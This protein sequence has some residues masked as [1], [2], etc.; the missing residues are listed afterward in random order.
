MK[1]KRFM[2]IVYAVMLLV[3]VMSASAVYLKDGLVSYY[4]F[5]ETSGTTATDSLGDNDGTISGVTIDQ[6]GIINKAYDFDGTNDFVDLFDT[7][8]VQNTGV[9]TISLWYKTS[10]TGADKTLLGQIGGSSGKGFFILR[11]TV[12]NKIDFY[13]YRGSSGQTVFGTSIEYLSTYENSGDWNHLLVTGDGDDVSMYLNGVLRNTPASIGTLSSGAST[14]N[15]MIG[16]Y[17]DNTGTTSYGWYDGLIDELGIWDRALNT[18]EISNLNNEGNGLNF[19]EFSSS[20]TEPEPGSV[21]VTTDIMTTGLSTSGVT[22][23]GTISDLGDEASVDFFFQYKENGETEWINTT[24]VSRS[25]EAQFSASISGLEHN[26]TYD[27]RA[28]AEWDSGGNSTNGVTRTFTTQTKPVFKVKDIEDNYL[29]NFT[30]IFDGAGNYTTTTGVVYFN[31]TSGS[32]DVTL[33]ASDWFNKTQTFNSIAPDNTYELTGAYQALI[34]FT[35]SEMVTDENITDFLVYVDD[36]ETPLNSSTDFPLERLSKSYDYTFVKTGYFNYTQTT[37]LSPLDNT[38]INHDFWDAELNINATNAWTGTGINNFSGWISNAEYDY[39]ESFSTTTGVVDWLVLKKDLNYTVFVES[40]GY[41]FSTETNYKNL[42]LTSN[43]TNTTFGLYTENS[44]RVIIKD[45]ATGNSITANTSILVTS[46][47]YEETFSTTSGTYLIENL[48]DN[49]Y[50]LRFTVADYTDRLYSV[51]VAEGSTQTLTAFLTSTTDTVIF[52]VLDDSSGNAIEGARVSMYA[53]IDAEWVTVESKRTDIT[54]KVQLL[55]SKN[56]RYKFVVSDD[57]YSS[58]T[59]ELNPVLF[60]NYNVRLVKTDVFPDILQGFTASVDFTP[61]YFYEG[62]NN[63]TLFFNSPEGRFAEYGFIINFPSSS[64]EYNNTNAIGETYDYTFSIVSP[65]FLDTV[66]LTYYY[67]L[68]GGEMQY[69]TFNLPILDVAPDLSF[70]DLRNNDYGLNTF[71]QLLIVTLTILLVGGL[72]LLT[73]GSVVGGAV[74]VLLLAWFGF[75]GF[76]PIW[77]LAIVILAGITYLTSKGV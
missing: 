3:T 32:Y 35:A 42:T 30:L 56:R 14:H 50:E 1:N 29:E 51:T 2:W 60:D 24:K 45:E 74:V 20:E 64:F 59:F 65:E 11:N 8:F 16:K 54:G 72:V 25:T 61:R 62:E 57:D 22:V 19:N 55:Y 28:F 26:T 33:V 69:R 38:T 47:T 76:I 18:T 49:E 5:D 77:S 73:A 34:S 58:K 12:T 6:T 4:K 75:L 67:R 70:A 40:E 21:V 15:L 43:V 36:S 39:N 66:N 63:L 7:N 13:A 17:M 9:F 48:T 53:I 46:D 37:L 41:G 68:V 23:Y 10:Q 27:Y 52:T 71:E 44:I 31:E